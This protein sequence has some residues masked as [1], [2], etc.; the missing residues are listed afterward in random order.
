MK[1][2]TSYKIWIKNTPS[3]ERARSIY[4]YIFLLFSPSFFTRSSSNNERWWWWKLSIELYKMLHADSF[5]QLITHTERLYQKRENLFSSF[6]IFKMPFHHPS[7]QHITNDELK[8]NYECKKWEVYS[9]FYTI[10][11][12]TL[13]GATRADSL[14]WVQKIR[15]LNRL[16]KIIWE[17][18]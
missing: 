9:L 18:K 4:T 16:K 2:N 8:K 17:E 7:S 15:I 13:I 5:Y 14:K 3:S 10:Y 12:C 11:L 1:S 6:V